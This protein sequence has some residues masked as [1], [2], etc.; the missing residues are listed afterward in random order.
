MVGGI[1]GINKTSLWN[2]WKR[3]R[4]Q[5]TKM[6][7]RDVVD[8]LEFDI[9][10][11]AWI[12]K[13]LK[14]IAEGIY[15]PATPRRYPLAK[16]KGFSRRMTFPQVRDV[17]LYRAIVDYL[18]L[19]LKR[20][21][22]KHV[23]FERAKLEKVSSKA[24]A[25]AR[26]TEKAAADYSATSIRRF[27]A[28]L[29]YSQYRKRLI[30]EEIYPYFIKTDITNYF[31]TILHGRVA[32]SLYGVS[33]P[34]RMVGLLFFLL[35]RLSI[36]D[37]Y[38]E[39][40]RIG[41]PVDEFDCSRKLAHLF[42]FTH[43]DRMAKAV[44]EEAYV[45]WMDDHIIGVSSRADGLK[46][47]SQLGDSLARLHL[48]PNSGKTAILSLSEARRHFHLDIN[49]KLA[50]IESLPIRTKH[51]RK[52]LVSSLHRTWKK[53]GKS[54]ILRRR[55][56]RDLLA[57]PEL[58]SRIADY[59]RC[60]GTSQEYFTFAQTVWG[61]PEQPYP[62]VN[63]KVMEGLLRLE[64]ASSEAPKIRSIA[65][66][67]LSG[68]L[69]VVGAVECSAL[70]PLLILR[71]GDRRSLPLLR[72]VFENEEDTL[73]SD[74]VRACAIVYA[75]FGQSEFDIVRKAAGRMLK[76]PLANMV[77]MVEGI[78]AYIEVPERWKLRFQLH[79]DSVE[80]RLFV[81]VRGLLAARLLA[82]NNRPA[83]RD[84]LKNRRED[85][86][87]KDIST[88]DQALLARFLPI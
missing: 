35:E 42:L 19:R 87:K 37:A 32:D 75:S 40:P 52:K 86:L 50:S 9:N 60:T 57:Y 10:P 59:M 25:L 7:F 64:A 15:E 78:M 4:K 5:L 63:F 31:D 83:I 61:H 26:E 46:I 11:E 33:A 56:I 51:E 13:L 77:K 54:R 34:S 49:D 23:Y 82:L 24:A 69:K 22:R 27:Y 8:Y 80:G 84:W 74:T 66:S 17:V 39:S 62:D 28:W 16:S 43:D 55:A 12:K 72:K 18:Y 68:T 3:V 88:Y 36:R 38:S 45:R 2:A 21:E 81:D 47:L 65:S 58:A 85:F 73:T 79:Y 6:A 71:F 30:F 48:T 70:A 44:G 29:H 53:L 20:R 67:L 41:I 76:N 14:E 1:R